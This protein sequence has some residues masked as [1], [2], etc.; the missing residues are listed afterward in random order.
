MAP[1]CKEGTD[2]SNNWDVAAGQ[3]GASRVG[4]RRMVA[5]PLQGAFFFPPPFCRMTAVAGQS[6]DHLTDTYAG[7]PGAGTIELTAEITVDPREGA[8]SSVADRIEFYKEGDAAAG[9]THIGDGTLVA[10]ASPSQY[11][12]SYSA[13]SH[14]VAGEAKTYFANCVARSAQ[15]PTRQVSSFSRPVRMRR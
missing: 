8:G 6:V 4:L 11:R 10:G 2:W 3:L 15:D 5:D 1:D 9:P 14:G 7:T 12:L 13:V